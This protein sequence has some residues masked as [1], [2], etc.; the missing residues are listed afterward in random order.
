MVTRVCEALHDEGAGCIEG[1]RAVARE[2]AVI[3]EAFATA[4]DQ[5][6]GGD[7]RPGLCR[8]VGY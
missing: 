8:S 5:A 2:N 4:A 7:K 1:P 6:T 3:D